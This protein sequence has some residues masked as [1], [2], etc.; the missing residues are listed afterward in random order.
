MC[1]TTLHYVN[2]WFKGTFKGVVAVTGAPDVAGFLE[3]EEA[4]SVK[5]LAFQPGAPI[6]VVIDAKNAITVFDLIKKQRLFVR[7]AR[8]IT[9]CMELL[10]G[11]NW[12]F[13]GLRDGTIDVFDVYRGQAVPYRIPEILPEGS[14]HAL[15]VS[16]KTHPKDSNQL[17]IAYN[18]GVALWNLKQKAVIRAFIYEIP[19]GA[20]GGHGAGDET[21]GLNNSR[22]PQVT[23]ISW[24]PDGLGFVSGYDDGCIVFWDV[25]QEKPVLARTIHDIN[26]NVPGNKPSIDRGAVQSVP[27]YQLSWCLHGNRDETTLIVAGGVGSVDMYGV[28]LFEFSAKHDYRYPRRHY[29]LMLDSDVLDFVVLPRESPWYN[30]GLDPVSIL[31][32]TSR[33]GLRSFDF[34]GSL[35]PQVLPSNLAVIEHRLIA[36]KTYGQLPQELYN[37]LVYG[38]GSRVTSRIVPRVPL[39]GIHL[40]P[41]DESRICRD[42]LVT[43][44]GDRSIRFWEGAT[45]RPLHHL[46]VE[47]DPLFFKDQGEITAFEFSVD[48]QVL[49]IGFSNG[50]WIYGSLAIQGDLS[51]QS[52]HARSMTDRYVDEALA[53]DL[54]EAINIS[55]H[56]HSVGTVDPPQPNPN[57]EQ[58]R[59]PQHIPPEHILEQPRSPQYIPPGH[60]PELVPVQGQHPSAPYEPSQ[61]QISHPQAVHPV[62]ANPMPP[63]PEVQE[64][65]ERPGNE[66]QP[67]ATTQDDAAQVDSR[68]LPL[69]TEGPGSPS[70]PNPVQPIAIGGPPPGEL[71]PGSPQPDRAPSPSLPP[72]PA[73]V[74]ISLSSGSEFSP[75]FKS[76]SHL[77]RVNQIAVSRCGL[78]EFELFA[79][80]SDEFYALSITDVRSGRVLHVEDLKVVTLDRDGNLNPNSQGY[81]AQGDQAPIDPQVLQRSGVVISTLQFVV[82]TTSDQD[83][84]PSLLLVAGSNNGIY[85]IFAISPLF[86]ESSL[87]PPP[88]SPRQ[89]RRV[90]FFQTKEQFSSVHT[91][92]INVLSPNENPSSPD[93]SIQSTTS[94]SSTLSGATTM[95]SAGSTSSGQ[96]HGPP[97]P[98]HLQSPPAL[99]PRQS[100]EGPPPPPYSGHRSSPS[101]SSV[102]D[103]SSSKQSIYS[104]WKEAQEKVMTKAQQRLNYLVCV[105]EFG[106]RLHMNCTSRRIHKV[107]LSSSGQDQDHNLH[108]LSNKVGRIMAANVVYHQGPCCIL[109][110]TESGRILLFSVPKLELIPLPVPGGELCLPIV[111]E[112]ERL[113]ETVILPDGRIF[114]PILKFEFRMYSLW[115]H[116]RWIQTPQGLTQERSAETSKYLQL[117]DH[118]I[119]IPPRP[120]ATVSKGWFGFGSDEEPPSQ[121]DLDELLGGEHYRAVNPILKR[122]GVQGP[123]GT[124]P[125]P[126]PKDGASTGLSGMMNETL[127]HL[128]ERGKKLSDIGERTAEM[129]VASS[130]FLAAARELNA[131][132]ANKKWYE[133]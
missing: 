11:S 98:T 38:Q 39:R 82:S 48:S 56:E 74:E 73:F 62:V 66:H 6:I 1:L 61:P 31:V 103:G 45:F 121:E 14:K 55:T 68:V 106:I 126:P 16:I 71:H 15:V 80:V 112:R 35:A 81:D 124:A 54:R 123:P 44:H 111:V 93:A 91:S 50:N 130:N 49:A 115:G 7:N 19:P 87:H 69:N 20:L 128:D 28:H 4:V 116:D 79:A 131:K 90:E 94:L 59:S 72:R 33:G 78:Y 114:V 89:V 110:V 70:S 46:T 119:Q 60:V 101:E 97:D 129:N 23:V 117:Y 32:L 3:L 125:L 30:G 57:L 92:I 102:G 113:R 17:L 85:L 42:I 63:L 26:V 88:P 37:R 99:P 100:L 118:G 108:G 76:S 67:P 40:A 77:G 122:A 10:P 120:T 75:V 104:T 34:G 51:R 5:M 133:F 27:I 83:K 13:H 21:S 53:N 58:P 22:Y 43:A 36:A 132:N 127:Q 24:R 96:T 105:S 9:T 95:S 18:T 41:V 2:L 12:L 52:S 86:A 65:H 8:S 47:L 109:C 64:H 29:Q 107:D 84:T 25:R